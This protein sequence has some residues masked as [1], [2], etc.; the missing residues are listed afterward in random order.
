MRPGKCPLCSLTPERRET[1]YGSGDEPCFSRFCP[2]R[3]D[4]VSDVWPEREDSDNGDS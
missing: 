4:T 1:L 2:L 3:D